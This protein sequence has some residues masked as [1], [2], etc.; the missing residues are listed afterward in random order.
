MKI[1]DFPSNNMTPQ[2]VQKID[3]FDKSINFDNLVRVKYVYEGHK[4]PKN[5]FLTS[6]LVRGKIIK[7]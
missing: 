7:I 1:R 5:E 3:D 6:H 4:L 2:K